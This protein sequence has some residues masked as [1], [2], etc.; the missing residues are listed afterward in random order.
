MIS[1]KLHVDI[2]KFSSLV[3]LLKRKSEG[4]RSK[5]SKVL[6]KGDVEK[7]LVEACDE[8]YL[9]TKVALIVGIA[10][11]CRREELKDL[12]F[13]DVKDEGYCMKFF[14]PVTKTKISRESYVTAGDVQGI[15]M[16]QIIRRYI[17]LRPN[18]V[19]HGRFFIQFRNGTCSKQPVGINTFGSMPKQIATYLKLED[20]AAYTGHCF[21]RSSTSMLADSGAD[22]V[23]VK[24]HG[25]WR[26]N[27]VAEGYIENSRENKRKIARKIL[28]DTDSTT[29]A[30]FSKNDGQSEDACNVVT[31]NTKLGSTTSGMN[32]N[33]C[34]NCTINIYSK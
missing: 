27:T 19:P 8:K 17:G 28:G 31:V 2:S 13:K 30:T 16:V 33:Q 9:F 15:D 32:L 7:F 12:L 1:L 26:S 22:L 3:A 10:G 11:G 6:E 21:R 24:R 14:L 4:Y 18:N 23:T 5:K 20:P 34:Q 29:E 25:G